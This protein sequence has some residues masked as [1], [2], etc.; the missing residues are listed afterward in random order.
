MQ[1]EM[2]KVGNTGRKISKIVLA[3]APVYFQAVKE[4]SIYQKH[5]GHL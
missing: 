2:D 4:N 3:Y 5:L 1:V